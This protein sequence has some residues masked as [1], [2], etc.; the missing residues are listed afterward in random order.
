MPLL[1][2]TRKTVEPLPFM[3]IRR[4]ASRSELPTVLGE[5]FGKVFTHCM[6]NGLPM[7]GFPLARYLSVSPGLVTVEAGVPLTKVVPGEG[8]LQCS[9]LPGGPVAFAI[10]GGPYD[11][12]GDTHAAIERW[13]QENRLR[14]SGPHWE[15]Y[16][17][18]PAEHPNPEDW[19][20]HIFYPLSATTES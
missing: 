2:I 1:S 11:Q 13:I 17:N 5:C 8:E 19:R 10:H 7:A 9:E 14:V 15:W 16:V 6:S 12:L 18:D 4:E 3:F 20:T